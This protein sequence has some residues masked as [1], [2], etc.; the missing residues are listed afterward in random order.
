MINKFQQI[1]HFLLKGIWSIRLSDYP[2]YKAIPIKMA[3]IKPP[4][5]L[6][7]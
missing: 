1:Q 6:I 5:S 4:L 2:K 3:D 7:V